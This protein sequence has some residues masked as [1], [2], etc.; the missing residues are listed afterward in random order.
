M[1]RSEA[2]AKQ[3]VPFGVNGTRESLLATAQ[4]SSARASYDAGFPP[5]TMT[6]KA[7]GGLPPKGPDFNQILYELSDLGRWGS[8]G[9]LQKFDATFSTAISGYPEGALLMSDDSSVIY[10]STVDDNTAN[11][12]SDLTGWVNLGSFL[13]ADTKLRSDL[14]S[15]ASGSGASL[16]VLE[17]GRT[18]QDKSED[19]VSVK[20]YGAVG[21]GVIHPLSETFNSISDAQNKYPFVTS[22]NQSIDWAAA[23]LALS[24]HENVHIPSGIYMMSDSIELPIGSNLQGDGVDSWS[25][26]GLIDYLGRS[27]GTNLVF[28]GSGSKENKVNFVSNQD[29]A[30]GVVDNPSSGA[31]HYSSAPTP[32]Y[33]L[34]NLTNSDA[35][36]SNAA[37]PRSFS[38]ALKTQ[39]I[40]EGEIAQGRG[41]S[42][43]IRLSNL[44]VIP[45]FNVMEGYVD[46]NSTYLPDDWDVGIWLNNAN[47][48]VCKN[49]QIVGIW[50]MA[51]TLLTNVNEVGTAGRVNCEG[52]SFSQCLLQ[53]HSGLLVRGTDN[54][55]I[56]ALDSESKTVTIT[57]S[58]GHTFPPTGSITNRGVTV[59]YSSLTFSSGTLIFQLQNDADMTGW[60]VSDV[61]RWGGGTNGTSGSSFIQCEFGA[62]NHPSRVVSTSTDF[63]GTFSNPGRCYEISGSLTRAIKFSLCSFRT[64]EDVMSF[65]GN[66]NQPSFVDCYEE[67]ASGFSS[68]GGAVMPSG[69]RSIGLSS[70]IP[71]RQSNS[72]G[73]L[74]TEI[75]NRPFEP[76]APTVSRFSVPSDL[77]L[78]NPASSKDDIYSDP[79]TTD[80]SKSILSNTSILLKPKGKSVL[81]GGY[82]DTDYYL[83]SLSLSFNILGRTR[84]RISTGDV[85]SEVQQY[86]FDSNG[87]VPASSGKNLGSQFAAGTWAKSYVSARYYTALVFDS[88]GSTSPEGSVTA[89]PGST[90][91][92]T[93]GGSLTS[94]YVKESGTGNTGWV[95]K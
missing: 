29:T 56:T 19:Y 54:F 79:F 5:I 8:A 7:S 28:Y 14:A 39:Y 24:L 91:R 26:L 93:S 9:A 21:D 27:K 76:L 33:S 95:A 81:I 34:S 68:L 52:N 78:W 32:N 77:G 53:G 51:A 66:S 20:D 2:P 83:S 13:G 16:V 85:G 90:Y 92:R 11:P 10:L 6:A 3:P 12:N 25:V 55:P 75:D 23:V 88:F 30:G 73:C 36:G 63:N 62:F 44:R 40:G 15:S 1:K 72:V 71:T 38:A 4:P 61:I 67:S 42:G 86:V 82:G 60:V 59:T 48:V 43:N 50:R 35:S 84:V 87:F 49:V 45:N 17:S 37:T 58:A 70:V 22:I 47:H 69:S 89:S 80:N 94:F 65:L 31:A 57:W 74:Y 46:N 64:R 18:V 41:L